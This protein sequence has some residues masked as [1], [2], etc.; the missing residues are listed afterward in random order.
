MSDIDNTTSIPP[1]LPEEEIAQI[2]KDLTIFLAQRITFSLFQP[3]QEDELKEQITKLVTD[4][5]HDRKIPL[6]DDIKEIIIDDI[7]SHM[8]EKSKIQVTAPPSATSST[9]TTTTRESEQGQSPEAPVISFLQL[10]SDMVQ[11]IAPILEDEI[12]QSGSADR[13]KS[14]ITHL[15]NNRLQHK[16]LSLDEET[17]ARLIEEMLQGLKNLTTSE[18][19][20]NKPTPKT[21]PIDTSLRRLFLFDIATHLDLVALAQIDRGQAYA[22]V[23]QVLEQKCAEKKIDLD[24]IEKKTFIHDILSGQNME[25]Q[26]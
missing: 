3:G 8:L 12:L 19:S 5:I 15:V 18:E 10:K 25:F 6:S 14:H 2:R 17:H 23:A 16:D 24:P 9:A 13:L 21:T 7:I 11:Y 22:Q 4:R 26:L 20:V 1:T